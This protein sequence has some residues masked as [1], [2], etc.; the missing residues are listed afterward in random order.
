MHDI[1]ALFLTMDR[2]NVIEHLNYF[3][4]GYLLPEWK[5]LPTH[6]LDNIY[7]RNRR[8]PWNQRTLLSKWCIQ[9]EEKY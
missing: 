4:S 1:F 6:E 7:K 3:F 9:A 2:V 5:R 8:Q